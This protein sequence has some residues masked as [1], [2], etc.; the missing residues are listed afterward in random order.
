M[1][2]PM[3]SVEDSIDSHAI[4]MMV[5]DELDQIAPNQPKEESALKR[6]RSSDSLLSMTSDR[7]QEMVQQ[8]LKRT[9]TETVV[10]ELVS[11][12]ENKFKITQEMNSALIS[13][14]NAVMSKVQ[15]SFGLLRLSQCNTEEKLNEERNK[16]Q[17][18]SRV[19]EQV[20]SQQE[21]QQKAL[22]QSLIDSRFGFEVLD[23]VVTNHEAQIRHQQQ[24]QDKAFVSSNISLPNIQY[25]QDDRGLGRQ[26]VTQTA[27]LDIIIDSR[28]ESAD[29]RPCFGVQSSHQQMHEKHFTMSPD[30]AC[31]GAIPTMTTTDHGNSGAWQNV[32]NN[33]GGAAFN[34]SCTGIQ[35]QLSTWPHGVKVSHP[36][37][38]DTTKFNAWK[39]EFLFWREL[40]S[41]LPDGYLL[42]VIG[43]GSATNLR[44]MI[45]KM[46]HDTKYNT[47]LRPIALLI[48]Y[49][50]KSYLAT[51]RER[52]MNALGKLL[53]I[54]R[55][56]AETV[57]AFWLRF[58]AILVTLENT[59]SV[60]SSEM[61]FM[62]A[63]KSLQLSYQQKT[64][65]LMM[66]DCQNKTHDI[67][68]L[69]TVS[70]RLFGLYREVVSSEQESRA[71][72]LDDVGINS[73]MEKISD[74]GEYETF[75][76]RRPKVGKRNKPGMETTAIRKAQS[77]TNMENGTMYAPK[78][79]KP[80]KGIVC[81]R[82]GKTDHTLR[83]CPLPFQP[84]L[85]FAPVRNDVKKTY[86]A[87]RT[88]DTEENEEVNPSIGTEQQEEQEN[89]NAADST[90]IFEQVHI[91]TEEEEQDWVAS[92]LERSDQITACDHDDTEVFLSELE[93]RTSR[94][95]PLMFIIDSGASS[96]CVAQNGLRT[97]PIVLILKYPESS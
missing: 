92:W 18:Q 67:E 59:S 86:I 69:K 3:K 34:P 38:L 45:M 61:I 44:L 22:S 52:E 2:D 85:A 37:T 15:N 47:S 17:Q 87:S 31:G 91:A 43:S 20:S 72:V 77:Q 7:V 6:R 64:S 13:N 79:T 49:L 4:M 68:N 51:S 5:G 70:I 57:Q 88:K 71:F 10:P 80:N 29:D 42:S 21:M 40:Y 60:L 26:P 76:M 23:S 62:R 1:S 39:K 12:V 53:D 95:S 46:F 36:P 54:R 14:A 11:Q 82:C 90:P 96:I 56:N 27:D 35:S 97:L 78:T 25:G 50:D 16:A 89:S 75:V 73:E 8:E 30:L 32:N 41:F 9:L 33:N 74:D 48:E 28:L 24:Q 93:T 66:M 55:E 94:S 19:L 83:Q 63:L 58:E 81:Y 84:K 65:V